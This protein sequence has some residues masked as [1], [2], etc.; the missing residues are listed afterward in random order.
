M[1]HSLIS[2]VIPI[3][4]VE[5][6]LEECLDSLL[7]QTIGV[8]N[9]EVIMVNDCS[10]DGSAAI[11][12]RYAALYVNFK[13][14]HFEENS[15]APGKPRNVG[16]K[17]ATGDYITFLDPDDY[18]P[19]EAY[20][21]LYNI[22]KKYDSDF[23]MG[24]MK[25]F[26]EDSLT[27][28]EHITFKDRL[29]QK[30]YYN[31]NIDEA[32]FFLQVKT[33]V[34]L[35]MIKREFLERHQI[36]FI[37]GMRNGEDK[38]FD[39]QLFKQADKFSYIPAVVYK[40]RIRSDQ[41]NLS[42]TQQDIVSSVTNDTKVAGIIKPLL[43]ESEYEYFQINVLRSVF[44]KVCHEDFNLLSPEEQTSVLA[45]IRGV[46]AT[47]NEDL[48]DRYFTW[49]APLLKLISLGHFCEA[50][51][52]NALLISRRTAY[53]ATHE[54][55]RYYKKQ[56]QIRHSL[57]WKITKPLRTNILYSLRRKL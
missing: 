30:E 4:N 47:Y 33:A 49:E 15:G 40:Y 3:Y 50:I 39:I 5:A 43:N 18:I 38:Y 17:Q 19:A 6:Y 11:I 9:L 14:I 51:E 57:S 53:M 48:V 13:A 25:M 45:M 7:N 29:M 54:L 52:Y 46:F 12:D 21:T 41:E 56:R 20:E 8:E 42:M 23:V 24:K 27:E 28:S 55:Q 31:I 16:I 35:K 37:E 2:V 36:T 34:W 1:N 26:N 44:W 32:L 10:T 22:C